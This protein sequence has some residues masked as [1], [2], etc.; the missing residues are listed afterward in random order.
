[1]RLKGLQQEHQ[2]FKIFA[3]KFD[4]RIYNTWEGQ[5]FANTL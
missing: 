2:F 5:I 1:M 4:K 3:L